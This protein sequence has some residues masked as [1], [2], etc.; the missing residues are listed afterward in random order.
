MCIEYMCA[1]HRQ[2]CLLNFD[3]SPW[4][5][6][7]LFSLLAFGRAGYEKELDGTLA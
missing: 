5:T 7:R 4:M 1:F 3:D 6:L 2:L